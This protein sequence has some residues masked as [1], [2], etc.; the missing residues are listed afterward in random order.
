M[1]EGCLMG[2]GA[3]ASVKP[4]PLVSICSTA[5]TSM[6]WSIELLGESRDGL[7]VI[8]GPRCQL[9]PPANFTGLRKK[10][11]H[12]LIRLKGCY[13]HH[14]ATVVK[15]YTKAHYHTPG[16]TKKTCLFKYNLR[17]NNTTTTLLRFSKTSSSLRSE[18]WTLTGSLNHI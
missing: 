14:T 2:S 1:P 13:V 15:K 11:W 17:I 5:E 8:K 18:V 9:P 7:P 4:L 10:M 12:T 16:L 6:G 3:E